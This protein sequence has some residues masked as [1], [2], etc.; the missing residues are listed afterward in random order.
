MVPV[1]SGGCA[2]SASGAASSNPSLLALLGLCALWLRRRT[3]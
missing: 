1:Q 2:V 3:R